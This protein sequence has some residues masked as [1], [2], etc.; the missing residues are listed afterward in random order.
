M[1]V[2]D[3]IVIAEN[4]A[5]EK[6]LQPVW[7]GWINSG[8]DDL[9][10]VAKILK[11]WDSGPLAVVDN[12]V[13]INF[14]GIDLED[15][16]EILN[17]HF[18]ITVPVGIINRFTQLRRLPVN[19]FESQGWKMVSGKITIQ[20]MDDNVDG[21]EVKVD[22]YDRLKYVTDPEE[23][24]TQTGLSTKYHSLILTYVCAKSQQKEEELEDKGDFWNEYLMAKAV[25][26]MDR[27]WEMEPQNRKLIRKARIMTW[28]GGARNE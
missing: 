19:D 13:V 1:K 21:I 26:A 17:L 8:L 9:T 25:M 28:F 10:P 16:H 12:E 5:E 23:D 15:A 24:L 3:I 27:T 22:Y 18:K 11:V 6:Y 14:A 20:G 4:L 2:S 7:L